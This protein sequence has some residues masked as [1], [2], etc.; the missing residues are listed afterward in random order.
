MH[1]RL[2]RAEEHLIAQLGEA[3]RGP[4]RNGLFA[5]W[6]FVRAC[7]QE[8]PPTTISVRARRRR[9][10]DL[11]RRLTSLSLAPG[12]RQ[13][14]GASFRALESLTPEGAVTGLKLLTPP[15]REYLG[16]GAGEAVG[17]AARQAR[18]AVRETLEVR[19]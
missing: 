4:K 2:A 17:L 11:E 10:T 12:L 7:E 8:L 3:A 16:A 13:A 15:A 19:Q 18:G 14:L 9:L 5:L 6:L 1:D